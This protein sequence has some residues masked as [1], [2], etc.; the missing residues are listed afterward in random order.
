[1]EKEKNILIISP[2]IWEGSKL[3]KHHYALAFAE[4]GWNV[5]FMTP[6]TSSI[7]LKDKDCSD[8]KRI[9][10]VYFP[11]SK[12]LNSL[13]FHF[14]PLYNLIL[15][16]TIRQWLQGY[17][18]FDYLISFDCN[19]V[20]TDLKNFRAK[21][22][23]FFPVDQV[24]GEFKNEYR[25]FD[26]LVSITPVILNSFP[27]VGNKSLFHHGLSS[28][29]FEENKDSRFQ[30]TRKVKRVG[31]VGNLL[32]GPIL[33]K[34][35]LVRIIENHP[36]IEFHF[37]GAYENKGNNL[38][39][40]SSDETR[41]F[42]NYLKEASN[43]ILHGV[44]SSDILSKELKKQDALLICYDFKYDKNECSNS[45]KIMEYLAT[46]KPV[47]STRISM[48]DGLDLFPMLETFDNSLFPEFF[49]KQVRNWADTNN[50]IQFEKRKQFAFRNTY[51]QKIEDLLK[52]SPQLNVNLI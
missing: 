46:G 51:S 38:G 42:V 12:Y 35:S 6:N 50:Q 48:Y 39:N 22:T 1:M 32:I 37:F 16:K 28:A 18:R 34:K 26:K 31:Y 45:H 11:I 23:V 3:S 30:N 25:G 9:R 49:D 5:Y 10:Q 8:H 29:F 27:H 20:F 2:E 17:P 43:C 40:D 15:K 21:K 13:R 41:R 14:R 47:I 36:E 33:D 52:F 4:E 7:P 44:V 24:T 19:G